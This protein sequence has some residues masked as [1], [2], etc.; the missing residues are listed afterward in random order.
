MSDEKKKGKRRGR[1]GEEG[2]R[3]G[4]G[5]V[6]QRARTP[7]SSYA[8]EQKRKTSSLLTFI[9]IIIARVSFDSS[10][11]ITVKTAFGYKAATL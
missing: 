7:T 4:R 10:P 6:R 5:L 11:V 2:K 9:A 3:T 1:G 8:N